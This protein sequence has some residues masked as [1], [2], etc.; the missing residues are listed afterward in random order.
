MDKPTV[1]AIKEWGEKLSGM[2]PDNGFIWG[3]A[4]AAIAKN[5]KVYSKAIEEFQKNRGSFPILHF[6]DGHSKLI[7]EKEYSELFN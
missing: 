3:D 6:K 4:L 5:S 1:D 2:K 7:S